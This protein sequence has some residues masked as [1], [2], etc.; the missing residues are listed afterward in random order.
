[1]LSLMTCAHAGGG[2]L[3]ERS[4]FQARLQGLQ[5]RLAG[6]TEDTVEAYR[7]D[8]QGGKKQRKVLHRTP[9]PSMQARAS[10]PELT[11]RTE[12]T[13]GGV[14]KASRP[15]LGLAAPIRPFS[16]GSKYFVRT[17]F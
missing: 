17:S 4:S 16:P 1:M 13:V 11:V 15:S 10:R 5:A 14:G 12:E 8:R 3:T 7:P 2:K 9:L 6:L